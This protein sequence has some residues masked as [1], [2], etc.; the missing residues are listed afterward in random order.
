MRNSCR[1]NEVIS[2]FQ[3]LFKE[4]GEFYEI[5]QDL[6]NDSPKAVVHVNV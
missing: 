2:L 4:I 5:L 6:G 1:F 3:I